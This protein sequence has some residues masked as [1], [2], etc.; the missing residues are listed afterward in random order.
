MKKLNGYYWLL[1][2]CITFILMYNFLPEKTINNPEQE[3]AIKYVEAK[4]GI[5]QC[6]KLIDE[7]MVKI[8]LYEQETFGIQYYVSE[9]Q[10]VDYEDQDVPDGEWRNIWE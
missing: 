7:N 8:W 2:V 5:L 3:Q 1:F 10:I 9:S 4:K 6:E